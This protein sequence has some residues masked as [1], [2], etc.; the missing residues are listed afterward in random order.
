LE[1][2][3]LTIGAM[4]IGVLIFAFKVSMGCGLASLR[5]HE[6]LSIALVYLALSVLI[7]TIVG[8]VL[9][10]GF[11]TIFNASIAIH[12]VVA[13]LL[14]F[15]GIVTSREWNCFGRDVSRRTFW[16]MSLPCP[17]SLAAA[18]LSCS[19]LASLA[20]VASWK[21]GLAVGIVFFFAIMGMSEALLRRSLAPSVLGNAMIFMGF[22]YM[23]S[24]LMILTSLGILTDPGTGTALTASEIPGA[25]TVYVYVL[26]MG[27]VVL[28]FIGNKMGVSL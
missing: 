6:I 16:A 2:S 17:A 5:R 13:L 1:S 15:L 24:M 3:S 19:S 7:G 22:S 8:L 20:G 25:D 26:L 10:G 23:L 9:D 11:V 14:I 18:S 12:A 4:L 27:M 28:G 21:A